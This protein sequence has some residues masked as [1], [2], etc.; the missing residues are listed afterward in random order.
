MAI[1]EETVELSW[2]G[3]RERVKVFN[4]WARNRVL[5]GGEG[6]EL[7]GM[8]GREEGCNVMHNTEYIS[9]PVFL[10][11]MGGGNEGGRAREGRR[12]NFFGL[13]KERQDGLFVLFGYFPLSLPPICRYFASSLYYFQL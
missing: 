3:G 10:F 4:R 2:K 9:S 5:V 6:Q 12:H 8:L 7:R 1:T 13:G 11:L